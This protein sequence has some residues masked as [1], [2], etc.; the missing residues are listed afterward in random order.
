MS[1]DNNISFDEDNSNFK[2]RV[3]LGAPQIPGVTKFLL[4]KK[5]V[6]DERQATNLMVILTILFL[7]IS[8]YIFAAHVFDI[9][10]FGAKSTI[11]P[12]QIQANKE[13]MEML[14]NRNI[15]NN[16]IQNVPQN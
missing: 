2:S 7:L 16:T 1:V 15:D 5:W 10:F 8:A 6:K 3:I 9:K 14:R 13:R 11:T 12:E 4:H